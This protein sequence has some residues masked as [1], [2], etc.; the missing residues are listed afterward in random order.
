MP[1]RT[2]R[3][4]LPPLTEEER[5]LRGRLEGHV[6][7]LAGEIGERSLGRPAGLA[8]AAAYVEAELRGAG[9]AVA[10]QEHVAGGEKVRN[11]EAEIL[12]TGAADE[13][14]VVGGHYD[15][16][17][18]MPGANDNA[19]GTAAVIEV[20]RALAG[21]KLS[22]TVRFVAFVN[23]EPPY[24]KTE[25]MGSRVYARRCRERGEKVLAMLS[26]ETIGYYRD[27]PGSQ[28][29]PFPFSL[30]YPGEGNFIGFVGNL[31][32]R[33][34]VRRCVGS[35]RSHTAF[36][37]EGGAL[38]GWITGVDWSDHWSFWKEGYPAVMVTD[39][40]PFRY[41]YYHHPGDTPDR[42]DYERTARVVAGI[43][44]VVVELAGNGGS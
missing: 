9:H 35:F 26:L 15:S 20:A 13:I 18:G 16:V 25:E 3:G 28:R 29:Y 12:G 38:P 7:T 37:S 30:F 33:S 42:I 6:R 23:E 34:L 32:S 19:S 21:R 2:H 43:A 10:S 44:R 1:G 27:E 31:G 14:V 5:A 4:P 17:L 24:F 41:P 8:R 22:R 39:T 40:A 11:I 36:P